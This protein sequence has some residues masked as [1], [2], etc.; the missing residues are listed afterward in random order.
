MDPWPA[1]QSYSVH[2]TPGGGNYG[3]GFAQATD[4]EL[5]TPAGRLPTTEELAPR[6][7]A[8]EADPAQPL[9]LVSGVGGRYNYGQVVSLCSL[10]S[11]CSTTANASL[12]G[13]PWLEDSCYPQSCPGFSRD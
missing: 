12:P 13:R 11:A 3:M 1:S 4:A 9:C 7:N 8:Q 5:G 6:N 2:G 10:Y